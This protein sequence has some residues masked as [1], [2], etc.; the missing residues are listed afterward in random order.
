MSTFPRNRASHKLTMV[1]SIIS[2][3]G[4]DEDNIPDESV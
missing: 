4:T 3:L 1:E 2:S